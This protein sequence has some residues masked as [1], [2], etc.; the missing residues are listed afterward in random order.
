MKILFQLGGLFLLCMLGE[1]ISALLPFAIPAGVLC[2]VML[3]LAFL[4][5]LV[6]PEVLKE[7]SDF[8]LKNIAFFFVPHSVG[9][10]K[11]YGM[12]QSKALPVI[13]ICVVSTLITFAATAY[14]VR[15]VAL[16]QKKWRKERSLHE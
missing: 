8:L 9:I 4:L 15:L 11:H 5:K 16:L 13:A 10:M 2:M 6:K 3:L 7:T 12:I 1:I 14:T